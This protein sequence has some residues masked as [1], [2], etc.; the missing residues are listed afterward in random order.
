MRTLISE[1]FCSFVD[2]LRS[3]TTTISQVS[4]VSRVSRASGLQCTKITA[5]DIRKLGHAQTG[6]DGNCAFQKLDSHFSAITTIN[7]HK[8]VRRVL[9]F[10]RIKQK[11]TPQQELRKRAKLKQRGGLLTKLT[12]AP[13]QISF[14]TD[15]G[16]VAL[17]SVTMIC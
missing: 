17:C 9:F 15:A 6:K 16:S 10:T 3:A 1:T 11:K 4:R 8:K 7:N 2:S 5:H 13:S 14:F 12:S